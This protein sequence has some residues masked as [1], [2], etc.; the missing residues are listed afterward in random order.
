MQTSGIRSLPPEERERS[1]HTGWTR[2]HWEHVADVLIEG[3]RPY[4]T[5][6]AG[7]IFLPRGSAARRKRM[8]GLEA[9][10]RTFLLAAFRLAGAGGTAPGDLADRYASGLRAGVDRRGSDA[11]PRITDRSQ[12]IVEAAFIALALFETRPWIWDRLKSGEQ[13]QVIAWL[14]GI[15]GKRVW[16]NNWV[17]FRV[18]VNAFLKSVG[19]PYR[20]D[21]I[22]RGL[23][24]VDSWYRRNGWYSDGAGTSFDYYVGWGIHF[25][26]LLW[27]RM[28]GDQSD[29]SRAAVYG[30]RAL[31]YLDKYRYFFAAN[32]AP[33]YHG[34]SLTYRFATAA[35]LW[36]GALLDSTPLGPGETRRIASGV[37]RHFVERGAIRD[38][39]LTRGWYEE[40]P[41]MVQSYSGHGSQYWASQAFLGLLLPP[42][43]PVWTAVEEPM[44]VERGDFVVTLPEPG[45]VLRGA[46]TDGI[47]TVASH[48]SD[49]YPLPIPKSA[50]LRRAAVRSLEIIGAGHQI[51]SL[52]TAD[53][54]YRKLA[55]STHAAP[56]ISD[57]LD[58]DSQISLVG[59]AGNVSRRVRIYTLAVVDR[60]AASVFYPDEPDWTSRVETVSIAW[61][62]AEIRVHHVTSAG[63]CHVRD[64]G[65]A[66]ASEEPLETAMGDVWAMTDRTGEL[67]SFI[68][69]LYGFE[70]G[71]TRA[72]E[73]AN[74]F[75]PHSAAPYLTARK[76]PIEA[77]YVSLVLLAGGPVDPVRTLG[78]IGAL[79]VEGRLVSIECRDG[80]RFFVQLVAPEA[81]DRPF[82][83]S[84]LN[85]PVRFARVSPDGSRFTYEE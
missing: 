67:V 19:A 7:L 47:V 71:T 11:W 20:E 70:R 39:L 10:A 54:H 28:D 26:T 44:P 66:I 60:F 36:A 31:Q 46:R 5:K 4:S 84:R 79:E 50:Y 62:A 45:F 12:P 6:T 33:L 76:K 42:E 53:P 82:G 83:S 27:R 13:E 77:V 17:L 65:F 24:L 52:V 22:A 55:Y 69:G 59:P 8:D 80:E 64:G 58:L 23:E 29:P 34:R 43:H 15:Q 74:P 51:P 21:E 1:P 72:M 81:V 2:A 32:G 56:D 9:F 30:R 61:G 57:D 18:T 49:H 14:S 38:G 25:F 68:G 16:A 78:A 41:P 3:V 85:G 37:L 73:G 75:G 48:R 35:P 63:D 40:F